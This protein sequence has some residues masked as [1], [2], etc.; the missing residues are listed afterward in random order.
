MAYE[1]KV[2]LSL[3]AKV[4]AKADSTEEVYKAI[5][6]AAKAGWSFP[7]PYTLDLETARPCIPEGVQLPTWEEATKQHK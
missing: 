3:L 2:I 5:E 1:T 7:N 4:T 6:E